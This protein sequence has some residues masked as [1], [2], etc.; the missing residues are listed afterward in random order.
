MGQKNIYVIYGDEPKTMVLEVLEK[1]K[2]R[3]GLKY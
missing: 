1:N 2:T 3:E